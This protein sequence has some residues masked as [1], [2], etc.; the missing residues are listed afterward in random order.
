MRWNRLIAM[1]RKEVIQILRDWRSLVIVIVLPVVQLLLFG[2]GVN[3]DLKHLP[4][5][6]WDQEGSQQSQDLLKRFQASRY[7]RLVGTLDNYAAATA[8]LDAGRAKLVLVVPY[9]FS[10][11]LKTGGAV[12][13]QALVD[14]TDDNTAN[15]VF[16]YS[17][18]VIRGFSSEVQLEFLRRQGQARIATPLEVAGRTWFNEDLESRAF[19]VPGVVAVVMAVLG[20]FLTSLTIAREWERGTMEQL[21]STPVTRLEV[22]LGK[23]APYFVIGMF[24]TALCTAMGMWLFQVPFRGRLTTLFGS[25]ALFLVVVLGLGYLIS[26]IAKTQL[27]ASQ[28]ALL[29]TFLPAFLLSGFLFSIDQ[30]PV[31]LQVFTRI[32]PARYYVTILKSVFLKGATA[33]TLRGEM[34]AL[35]LFAVV[36]ATLATR[37]F[38]KRLG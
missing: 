8:A 29:S 9:D 16:A 35:A 7:F 32:V 38:H 28:I 12:K 27:A 18:A 31:A 19:V 34:L 13:V 22:M 5:Y 1:A 6:V 2:Y 26:V 21:I 20:A 37:A 10:Q 25:A 33:A 36:V 23:L 30:M 3:L 15:L 11:R 24:D 4:A 17:E 14:A